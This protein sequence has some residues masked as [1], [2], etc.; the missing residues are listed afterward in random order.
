MAPTDS[1]RGPLTVTSMAPRDCPDS[2]PWPPMASHGLPWPPLPWPPSQSVT[3]TLL[4]GSSWPTLTLYSSLLFKCAAGISASSNADASSS[5]FWKVVVLQ[6]G[7]AAPLTFYLSSCWRRSCSVR[8]SEAVCFRRLDSVFDVKRN[9]HVQ[10]T[11]TTFVR[12]GCS[13]GEWCSRGKWC[14]RSPWCYRAIAARSGGLSTISLRRVESG[15]R[16]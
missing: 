13:R 8:Q 9:R 1:L 12:I 16:R 2:L 7:L 15:P 11:L 5:F 6:D 10:T 14:S 4:A 3:T